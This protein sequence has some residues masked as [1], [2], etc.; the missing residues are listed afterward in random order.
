L[1]SKNKEGKEGVWTIDLKKEGK[2]TKGSGTGKPD[3]VISCSGA[4]GSLAWI[5]DLILNVELTR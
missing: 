1:R 5:S 3:V 4:S 2:V